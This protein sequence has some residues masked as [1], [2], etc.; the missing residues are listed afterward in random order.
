MGRS[1]V[2]RGRRKMRRRRDSMVV[3]CKKVDC[4]YD[5]GT[6]QRKQFYY[7][8]SAKRRSQWGMQRTER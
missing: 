6:A 4:D 2:R 7:N 8:G 3:Y 1:R 5:G